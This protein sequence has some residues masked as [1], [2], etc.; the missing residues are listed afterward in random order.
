MSFR[1]MAGI[2]GIVFFALI[3][4]NIFAGGEPPTVKDP[5]GDVVDYFEDSQRLSAVVD[6]LAGVFIAVFGA[7]LL[8][9]IWWAQTGGRRA[10]A[11]VGLVGLVTT[12]AAIDSSS[13][14]HQALLVNAG[15]VDENTLNVLWDASSISF[16][17][18]NYNAGVFLLG[19]G[20]GVLGTAVLPKWLGWFALVGAVLGI[21]SSF[22]HG[23]LDAVSGIAGTLSFL[24]G[25]VLLLFVLISGIVMATR[26]EP[27]VEPAV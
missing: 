20:M 21:A 11:V 22:G 13:A 10:W 8:S 24:A 25:A 3:L 16:I 15:D 18:S 2:A 4:V 19:A 23:E 14:L 9:A 17:L 27:E 12:W 7:G 5:V 6:Q 1:R 26:D